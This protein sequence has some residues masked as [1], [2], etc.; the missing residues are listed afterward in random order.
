MAGFEIEIHGNAEKELRRIQER[1]QNSSALLNAV[2]AELHSMAE[3]AFT[4]Q[5][6]PDGKQWQALAP[7]TIHQR[8]LAANGGSMLTRTGIKVAAKYK[9]GVAAAKASSGILNHTSSLMRTLRWSANASQVKLEAGPHP[10][11]AAIHQLGGQ[12]GR[13]RK[14]KIPARPWWPVAIEGEQAS[15]TPAGEKS[16]LAVMRGYIEG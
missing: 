16:V 11:G 13:G 3:D 5:T 6:S 15:L 4:D 12:A 2:G 1:L 7:S 8:G 9:K 14:V 10:S